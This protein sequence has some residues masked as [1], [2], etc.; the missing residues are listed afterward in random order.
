[1]GTNTDV[2]GMAA[3]LREA[4][5]GSGTAA[6]L[7]A[8]ATARSALAALA[9]LAV[10]AATVYARRPEAATGLPALG[11]ALGITVSVESFLRADEALVCDLVVSTVPCGGADG[12]AGAVP[13]GAG[14][15]HDVLYHPWP[16]PLARSWAEHDGV[17]VSGLA[18]LVH[19][20]ARQVE[21]MTGRPAPVA[22]MWAAGESALRDRP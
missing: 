14:L 2:A 17:V 13:A 20:A 5:A 4:G 18:L 6:V 19:Q 12:L 3:A 7:G 10:P 8:G 22:A 11:E 16:T 21:L 9:D 15:L 1:V